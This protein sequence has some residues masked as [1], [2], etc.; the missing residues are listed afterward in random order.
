MKYIK[1]FES[2]KQ[3]REID[4]QQ[5]WDD[6]NTYHMKLFDT[7]MH[8]DMYFYNR[9]LKPLL[10]GKEIEFHRVVNRFDDEVSYGLNGKVK[11]IEIKDSKNNI[12]KEIIGHCYSK[13]NDTI[14]YVLARINTNMF[15][16][17]IKKSQIIKI[18][19]SEELEI[20]NKIHNIKKAEKYNT[21]KYNL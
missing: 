16:K 14:G 18:Y 15:D 10:I 8:T 20:E 12:S 17:S 21:E 4:L 9:V 7:P 3:F 2:E 11:E 13:K 5:L 19:N 6:I 1:K